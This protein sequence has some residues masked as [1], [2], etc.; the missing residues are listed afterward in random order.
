VEPIVL[1]TVSVILVLAVL[2]E[3]TIGLWKITQGIKAV[4]D[5]VKVL[6]DGQKAIMDALERIS[7][8]L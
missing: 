8:R 5:G 2:V 4:Q 1:S 6:Q 3:N 7:K